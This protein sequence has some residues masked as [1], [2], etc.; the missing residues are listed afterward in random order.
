M[1]QL[2]MIMGSGYEGNAGI[3]CRPRILI[4]PFKIRQHDE[5]YLLKLRVFNDD[6]SMKLFDIA[7]CK[8][9]DVSQLCKCA[10]DKKVPQE[11]RQFLIDQRT[12]HNM[13]IGHVDMIGT[14]KLQKRQKRKATKYGRTTT[15]TTLSEALVQEY[16]DESCD[17]N[18]ADAVDDSSEEPQTVGTT[19]VASTKMRLPMQLLV[20]SVTQKHHEAE[21]YTE[22]VDWQSIDRCSNM[23]T[24]MFRH[25]CQTSMFRHGQ[26]CWVY[27]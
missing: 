19:L 22:L 3:S 16:V 1:R 5:S 17:D 23:E 8:C 18:G 13:M 26:V 2:R 21:D 9:L 7:S 15:S 27:H 25:R 6:A 14:K 4:K 12:S 24:S 10:N 20:V 11:E